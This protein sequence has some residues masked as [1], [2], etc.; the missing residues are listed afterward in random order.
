MKN[1][2]KAST[3]LLIL[4]GISLC[5]TSLQAADKIKVL[6]IDGQNNHKWRLTTPVLVE[7]LES[8]GQ[9]EVTVSTS[10]DKGADKEAWNRWKPAFQAANVVLSNYNGEDWPE[11]VQTAF[12]DFVKE[13]GGFVVVH[14][15]DNSFGK[16]S[17]YNRMIG[18][19]GWGGRKIGRDGPWVHVVDGKIVRDTE[20]DMNGGAHGGRDPFV[21]EHIDTHH[22]ITKG[23]PDKWLHQGDEL[24]CRLCGPAENLEVQGTALSPV[25]KRN[26]PM[27][28]TITY[29]KGRVFHTPM[30][31]DVQAMRCRGFYTLLQRGTEWSATGKVERTATVPADFPTED[32]ISVVP[33]P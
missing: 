32:K 33:A 27:L 24:Y 3:S 14:A 28:M 1:P 13:G 22:P 18:V 15:A 30:G 4:S 11:D 21:V 7:A 2:F 23:L 31:H 6:L 17:E 29:G 20:T 26:E 25:T 9:F 10:P 8:C 16:W 12:V 5:A 19:G